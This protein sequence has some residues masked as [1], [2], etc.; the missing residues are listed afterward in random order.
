MSQL[1]IPPEANQENHHAPDPNKASPLAQ[2]F[3]L[4]TVFAIL[5]SILLVVGGLM[6]AVSMVK[7][8]DPT[9]NN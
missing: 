3:F 9:T 1:K 7:E 6:A 4:K 2:F 5:L 8:G